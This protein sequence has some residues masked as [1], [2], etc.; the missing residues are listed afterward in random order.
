MTT[1]QAD[2]T[3]V[4]PERKTMTVE[5]APGEK[6]RVWS[7][8]FKEEYAAERRDKYHNDP[9]YRA[10]IRNNSREAY[11]AKNPHVA[12]KPRKVRENMGKIDEIGQVREVFVGFASVGD[13][14]CLTE[15]EMAKLIGVHPQSFNRMVGKGRWPKPVFAC[16]NNRTKTGVYL[17]NEALAMAEVYANHLV[18]STHYFAKHTETKKALEQAALSTR[19]STDLGRWA[20]ENALKETA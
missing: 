1:P 16:R 11:V 2:N 19:Q 6:V 17:R 8:E 5:V 4:T 9:E 13:E 20:L 15:Q 10:A 14:M 18:Q 7:P 12:E 3:A